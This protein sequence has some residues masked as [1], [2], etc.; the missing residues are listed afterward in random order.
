MI[1]DPFECERTRV[2][3][4]RGDNFIPTA[5][6]QENCQGGWSKTWNVLL[7]LYQLLEESPLIRCVTL[8]VVGSLGMDTVE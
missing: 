6:S 7:I 1:K 5:I 2:S 8:V 3:L 4:Y